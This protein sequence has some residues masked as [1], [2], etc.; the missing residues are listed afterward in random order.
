MYRTCFSILFVSYLNNVKT[1]DPFRSWTVSFLLHET[2]SPVN[3]TPNTFHERK[4]T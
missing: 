3:N 4:S 2:W 1:Q